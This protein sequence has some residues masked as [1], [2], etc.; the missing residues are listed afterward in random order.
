MYSLEWY[1]LASDPVYHSIRLPFWRKKVLKIR[2]ESYHT[3]F[4]SF[5]DSEDAQHDRTQ[6]LA[7]VVSKTV[8]ALRRNKPQTNNLGYFVETDF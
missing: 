6:R 8:A 2:L 4:E 1:G 7:Y 3:S 5:A